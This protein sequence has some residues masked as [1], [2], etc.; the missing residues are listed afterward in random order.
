VMTTAASLTEC[1]A[2][3]IWF[4]GLGDSGSSWADLQDHLASMPWLRWSFPDAPLQPVTCN[5]G[6]EMPSWFDLPEIPVLAGRRHTGLDVAVARVH[7]MLKDAEEQGIPSSRVVLG[8]FSQGG[9]LSLRAGLSYS[10]RLAGICCLSGWADCELPSTII[11]KDTPVLMCH[12]KADPV[13]PF[14]SGQ[15]SADALRKSSCTS[16]EFKSYPGL[17]HSVQADEMN[18]VR[19]F[20]KAVLPMLQKSKLRSNVASPVRAVSYHSKIENGRCH[21]VFE[22]ETLEGVL[23]DVSQSDVRLTTHC[24]TMAPWPALINVSQ[25][26]AT[27]SRKKKQLVVK[28][29]ALLNR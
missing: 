23:L 8:G 28:A 1:T 29:P 5:A 11:Q 6:D 2:L 14:A 25:A 26:I 12:G 27:F 22:V 10:T 3:V 21:I 24:S 18:D 9:A 13:V 16:V 20:F 17:L 4:H 15:K 19:N 7:E